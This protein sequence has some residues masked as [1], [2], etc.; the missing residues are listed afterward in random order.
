MRLCVSK[1]DII[2]IQMTNTLTRPRILVLL[3]AL[4]TGHI[5][6]SATT[7][8][9]PVKFKKTVTFLCCDNLIIIKIKWL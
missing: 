9:F 5:A 3:G 1:G 2:N 7:P 6:P 4:N 8:V